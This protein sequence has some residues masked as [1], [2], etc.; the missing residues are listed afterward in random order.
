MQDLRN[1]SDLPPEAFFRL[2]AVLHLTGLSRSVLYTL[3]REGRFPASR[4]LSKSASG[5][6][7]GEVRDWLSDPEGW[8]RN[9]RESR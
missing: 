2:P 9:G 5:W 8:L 6:R 7:V 4:R 3:V 1:L